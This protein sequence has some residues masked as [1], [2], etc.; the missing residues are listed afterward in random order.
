MNGAFF[1][2]FRGIGCAYDAAGSGAGRGG[3][4]EQRSALRT[5][6]AELTLSRS[7]R[8]PRDAVAKPPTPRY[9]A[10]PFIYVAMIQ[11]RGA[12]PGLSGSRPFASR[13]RECV[14]VGPGQRKLAPVIGWRAFTSMILPCLGCEGTG[15]Q[16]REGRE[17]DEMK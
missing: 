9:R 17:G 12:V 13:G 2:F 15:L 5:K 10:W 3:G 8:G 4:R 7:H 11:E 1:L 14:S 16:E 6:P